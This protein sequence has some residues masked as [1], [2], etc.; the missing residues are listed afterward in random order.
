MPCLERLVHD[1]R[2]RQWRKRCAEPLGAKLHRSFERIGGYPV[3]G[4]IIAADL[5]RAAQLCPGDTV[6][7]SETTLAEAH[8]LL[9]QQHNVLATVQQ[10][11]ARTHSLTEKAV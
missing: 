9:R 5:P 4:H 2:G 8:R 7:F 1:R 6:C 10:G 3:L 11:I